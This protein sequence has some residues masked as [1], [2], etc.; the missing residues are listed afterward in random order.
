M[1]AAMQAAHHTVYAC[2][3]NN[4]S[5]VLAV[6]GAWWAQATLTLVKLACFSY[7]S[8]AAEVLALL[9]GRS[10]ALTPSAD[11]GKARRA[12]LLLR[13]HCC[14]SAVLAASDWLSAGAVLGKS[15]Y[16]RHGC[17]LSSSTYTVLIATHAAAALVHTANSLLCVRLS[18]QFSEGKT[19]L[20]AVGLRRLATYRPPPTPFEGRGFSLRPLGASSNSSSGNGY[21]PVAQGDSSASPSAATRHA[22]SR[23]PTM[24]TAE[25]HRVMYEA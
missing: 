5:T 2:L 24:N 6:K 14:V 23:A 12:A 21:Q 3:V 19:A 25:G 17:G 11:P 4:N 16:L 9:I 18:S 8:A 1:L 10:A 13:A 22:G 15:A 20:C 7:P